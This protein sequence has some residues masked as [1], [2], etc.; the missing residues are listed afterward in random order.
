MFAQS[1]ACK[2]KYCLPFGKS[3]HIQHMSHVNWRDRAIPSRPRLGQY[4]TSLLSVLVLGLAFREFDLALVFGL[5]V[6]VR[7]VIAVGVCL[8]SQAALAC[9]GT[10]LLWIHGCKAALVTSTVGVVLILLL[11]AVHN[12]QCSSGF[13]LEDG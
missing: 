2:R 8:R 7:V 4:A 9:D 11:V 10:L 1:H 13:V 5:L 12:A 3:S 6:V